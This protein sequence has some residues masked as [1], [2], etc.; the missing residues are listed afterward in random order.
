M[1]HF[2][3]LLKAEMGVFL[4]L[5]ALRPLEKAPLSPA[6]RL[7]ALKLLRDCAASPGLLTDLFANYDCDLEASNLFE[8]MLLALTQVAQD[9]S[10]DEDGGGARG[11]KEM[12]GSMSSMG[13]GSMSGSSGGGA[14]GAAGGQGAQ[15]AVGSAAAEA[16]ECLLQA[17]KSFERSV[18]QPDDETSSRESAMEG[19]RRVSGEAGG[20]VRGTM[21]TS[22][23]GNAQPT[24]TKQLSRKMTLEQ[25]IAAFNKSPLKGLALLQA[26]GAVGPAASD[27]ARFLH[28]TP[29]L[30]KGLIG[31]VLGH[32]ED[33]EVA[34]MHAYV[35]LLAFHATPFDQALR[36]FL[37]VRCMTVVAKHGTRV[38]CLRAR[39]DAKAHWKSWLSSI[40]SSLARLSSR[41][42]VPCFDEDD[43]TDA[44]TTPLGCRASG[45]RARRRRSTG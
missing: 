21:A 19:G 28:A 16:L 24:P 7:A 29:G 14:K 23:A 41:A 32:H 20:A 25:G 38:S 12:M 10:A 3:R 8:R 39:E 11:L 5:V 45:C 44:R 18:V 27:V 40:L 31:E 43:D 30:D 15:L 9:Y 37:A 26:N 33:A 42:E 17:M 13:L 6:H 1:V 34:V 36:L 4:P 35:E 22:P 2:R